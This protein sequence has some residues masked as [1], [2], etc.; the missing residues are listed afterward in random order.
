MLSRPYDYTVFR[1]NPG[2]FSLFAFL[3]L[4]TFMEIGPAI[5]REL[6]S[7]ELEKLF[8]A[9]IAASNSDRD[10]SVKDVGKRAAD[11]SAQPRAWNRGSIEWF[12]FEMTNEERL[13]KKL[14]PLKLNGP[15]NELAS[16]H[17]LDMCSSR[18]LAHESDSFPK[19]RRKFPE[20]MKGIGLKTGAENIAFHSLSSDNRKVAQKVM[21]GWMKS[22][23]H[24]NNIL[25]TNFNYV[26]FGLQNCQDGL[27]YITQLFTDR[28]GSP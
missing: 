27:I 16:R 3:L 21:E 25:T 10:T 12:L 17:S 18:L 13:K 6:E 4:I 22:S 8:E 24:R 15:M 19:G 14:K 1:M 2:V 26:G 23:E 7:E 11:H 5:S 9:S 20:R 28:P